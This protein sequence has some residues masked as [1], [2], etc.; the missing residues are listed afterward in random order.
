MFTEG[1]GFESRS[2]QQS[3]LWAKVEFSFRAVPYKS[4]VSAKDT[5]ARKTFFDFLEKVDS[6]EKIWKKNNEMSLTEM[7]LLY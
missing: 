4:D 1:R 5:S 6:N 2:R 3:A 7:S